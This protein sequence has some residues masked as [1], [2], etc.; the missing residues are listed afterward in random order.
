[1]ENK[2]DNMGN[3]EENG[4]FLGNS[5]VNCAA[6]GRMVK[7]A[8]VQTDFLRKR[9]G[10]VVNVIMTNGFQMR[11]NLVSFDQYALRLDVNG[12]DNLV[13]KSAIS[14]IQ[15]TAPQ[16]TRWVNAPWGRSAESAQN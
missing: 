11:G 3:S 6:V 2:T 14:T 10:Q 8:N 13:Y 16:T 7:P 12:V 9:V 15:A 5:D 1:M 4:R